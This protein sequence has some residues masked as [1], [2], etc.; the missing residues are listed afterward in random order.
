MIATAAPTKVSTASEIP[1]VTADE[2]YQLLKTELARYLAL[3]EQLGP[4]DWGQ[5]TACTA[6]DVRDMLA[7]QAGGYASGS[8][9]RELLRQ[10]SQRPKPGQLPEDALN[11]FQLRERAGKS[12]QELITELRRVGPIAARK[13]AYEFRPLKLLS[14][15]HEVVGWLS[16]RHLMWV[17]HSRDT[18]MHR[19]DTCRATGRAFEQTRAH[20]GRIAE[21]VMRDVAAVLARKYTGPALHFEL[22]GLA[23]GS[24]QIGAGEPAATIQMD[25]L[26]FNIFAS[27]RYTYEQARPLAE[28]SG[29]VA[30]AEAAL[31]TILVLY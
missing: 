31:K 5:P 2:A 14:I 6:W 23:G 15:P 3:V 25:V 20:D 19:L 24:W 7:H 16:L 1:Y 17:I 22:T 30:S 28:I 13:W 9:Y 27:G 29:D 21:L 12:P 11:E 4:Q 8:S 10:V 26:E 18:W